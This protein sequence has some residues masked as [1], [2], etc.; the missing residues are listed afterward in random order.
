MLKVYSCGFLTIVNHKMIDQKDAFNNKST[1]FPLKCIIKT[2]KHRLQ[3][4]QEI[5]RYLL[6]KILLH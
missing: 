4:Y 2:L 1:A 3:K 5:R 6:K